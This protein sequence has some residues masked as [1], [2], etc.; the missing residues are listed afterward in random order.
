MGAKW[1]L[2]A[3]FSFRDSRSQSNAVPKAGRGG[4]AKAQRGQGQTDGHCHL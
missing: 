3:W 4:T 2:D 1:G